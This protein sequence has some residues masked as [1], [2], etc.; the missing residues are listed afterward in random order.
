MD[1]RDTA[2]QLGT[3]VLGLSAL[4]SLSH[5]ASFQCHLQIVLQA[6]QAGSVQLSCSQ[7]CISTGDPNRSQPQPPATDK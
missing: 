7:S 6:Q 2:F 3:S 4:S 5:P 1:R